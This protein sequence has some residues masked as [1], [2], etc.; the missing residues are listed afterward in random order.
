MNKKYLAHQ[1]KTSDEAFSVLVDKGLVLIHG[2]PRVG[3]TRTAIRVCE[4]L[5]IKRVLVLTKKA[6]ISGWESEIK[7]VN[8]DTHFYV[9]NYEQAKKLNADDYELV[10]A[11][12]SHT[13]GKVGRPTQRFLAV[14]KLAFNKPVIFLSGTPAVEKLLTFYYQFT[15]TKYSPFK[16]F[17]NFYDFFRH[18]GIPN[19]IKINGNT[20]EQYNRNK[21]ELVD[22]VAPYIVQL[23]QEQA[24]I[25]IQA[26]DKIH[27][28]PLHSRTKKLIAQILEHSVA[29]IKGKE[30]GFDSD[31]GVRTVVHQ[32]ESGAALLDEELV[33]LQ[34]NEMVDYIR[35]TFG[36]SPDVAVMAHFRSTRQKIAQHLP[37]VHI[38]SS[39]G[40]AEGV[41][42]ADYKHFVIANSGYSGAKF[43]QRRE[44]GVNLNK[45]ID[46]VVNHLVTDAGVSEQVYKQVSKKL[47][48]NLRLFRSVRKRHSKENNKGAGI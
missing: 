48:F 14:R 29:T 18:Y 17:K 45:K 31:M 22:V 19:T 27:T 39:D 7:A 47:D 4:K 33:M 3:K 43:I 24:G 44:R 46:S 30:Y 32:I 36:D 26:V 8:P 15:I 11:D 6:A 1:I 38:Y 25:T 34:N 21:P 35:D 20:I 10:I 12:E 42:L 37:N 41:S 2:D 13:L 23:T 28:I 40:N 16:N 5:P 9:T